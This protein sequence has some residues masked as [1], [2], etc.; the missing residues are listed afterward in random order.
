V[1]PAKEG[2]LRVLEGAMKVPTVK[3]VVVTSSVAAIAYGHD[4]SETVNFGPNDWTNV[5]NPTVTPYQRS[6]TAAEQL[7]WEFKKSRKPSFDI[8]TM[9]PGMVVGPLIS[10]IASKA[11][12]SKQV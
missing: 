7:V 6:K 2:T 9:N 4:L 1:K 11:T 12:S 10:K 3:R 8:C 5:D